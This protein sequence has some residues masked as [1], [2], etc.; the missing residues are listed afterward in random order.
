MA[1]FSDKAASTSAHAMT[2]ATRLTDLRRQRARAGR[3][4]CR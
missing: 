2:S 1:Y 3:C 4:R